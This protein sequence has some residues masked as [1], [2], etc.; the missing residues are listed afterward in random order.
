M[1]SCSAM[2]VAPIPCDLS[3]KTSRL[4]LFAVGALPSVGNDSDSMVVPEMIKEAPV[5]NYRKAWDKIREVADLDNFRL[6]DLRHNF[7]STVI[8]AST[9]L[10]VVGALLGHENIKATQ[11]YAHL[12]DSVVDSADNAN[13]QA[14]ADKVAGTI[15]AA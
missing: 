3:A 8:N 5:I 6:H 7:A 15:G 4:F 9:S 1:P 14:T 12:A 2:S 13:A 11:R 10:A